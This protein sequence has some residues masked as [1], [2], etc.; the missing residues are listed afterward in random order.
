MSRIGLK[1]VFLPKDATATITND[2]VTIKGPKGE[3]TLKLHAHA[4]V[5]SSTDEAGAVRLDVTVDD[6]ERK[7]RAVWGTM[8]AILAKNVEG[9]TKGF[10]RAL[11]LNG[12][13]FKMNLQ[14][15]TLNFALGFSHDV[16]FPLPE[17][18]T[19]K[20]E[21]NVLTLT[22]ASIEALG[23]VAAEIRALKKPEPYKGKGFRYTDEIIRRKAG[24]AS[25][26]E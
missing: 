2:S 24:K 19:A 22:A 16:K 8:R 11:E 5:A 17:G 12:V 15:T 9:V 14:G 23:K 3:L 18:V 26:S 6:P 21:T 20:I 13:G 25:K 4:H 10:S 1:P 7:D